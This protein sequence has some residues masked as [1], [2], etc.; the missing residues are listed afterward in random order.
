MLISNINYH[1]LDDGDR[2]CNQ[3]YQ[4]RETQWKLFGRQ[5]NKIIIKW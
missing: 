4:L 3:L 2:A 5:H 1:N